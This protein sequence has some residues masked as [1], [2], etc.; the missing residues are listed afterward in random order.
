MLQD[1]A[2]HFTLLKTLVVLCCIISE[3]AGVWQQLLRAWA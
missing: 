3:I 1:A 2:V